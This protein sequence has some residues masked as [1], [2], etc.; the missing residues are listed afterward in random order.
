MWERCVVCT[1]HHYRGGQC[2]Q[3]RHVGTNALRRLCEVLRKYLL[4]FV[5]MAP[6]VGL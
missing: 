4:L 6:A 5:K 2:Q 1:T 3:S